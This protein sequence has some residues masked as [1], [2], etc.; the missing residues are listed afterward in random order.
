[1]QGDQVVDIEDPRLVRPKAQLDYLIIVSAI[2][3]FLCGGEPT[4]FALPGYKS[5]CRPT[6]F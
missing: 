6:D 2:F 5:F 3:H 1:M 4:Y